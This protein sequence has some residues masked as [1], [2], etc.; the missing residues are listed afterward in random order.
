MLFDY[1]ITG[2]NITGYY[3]VYDRMYRITLFDY[4]S[5]RLYIITGWAFL[6]PTQ[7]T[8]HPKGRYYYMLYHSI[9]YYIIYY[10]IIYHSILYI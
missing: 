2:Y 5:Y 10:I 1:I 8:P 3:L 6:R 7:P 4:I 9:I